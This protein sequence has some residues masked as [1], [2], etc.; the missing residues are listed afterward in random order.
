MLCGN[1]AAAT[2]SNANYCSACGAR[3]APADFVDGERRQVTALFCDLVGSTEIAARLDPEQWHDIAKHYRQ[4][5]GGEIVKMG[6]HVT[7]YLGDG[8]VA[9]FGYPVAE[10][11]ASERAVRAGLAIVQSMAALNE[12]YGALH[13]VT[14]AVRVGLHSG[15]VVVAR[16]GDSEIGMFGDTPNIAARV[17]EAARP[18]TVVM[19][20]LVH[21]AVAGLFVVEALGAHAFK[22]VEKP[23]QLFRALRRDA[24][25]RRAH[26]GGSRKRTNFVGRTDEMGALLERQRRARAGNGQVVLI[27]GEAGIGKTRLLEEFRAGLKGK[28]HLWLDCGGEPL[29]SNTP[30]HA[31]AQVLGLGA[32]GE[33]RKKA[34]VRLLQRALV[35]AKLNIAETLPL[36]AEMLDLPVPERVQPLA[37]AAEQKR[38]QLLEVLASWVLNTARSEELLAIAIEDVHWV[39]PSTIE[40]MQILAERAAGERLLIVATARPDFRPPWPMQ[41]HHAQIALSRLDRTQTRALVQG[42]VDQQTFDRRLIESLAERADGVPLFAEELARN[43]MDRGD[44]GQYEI[45]P[46]LRDSLTAR[47]DR[48][49]QAKAVA[50]L[51]AVI[52][53]EFEYGLLRAVSMLPEDVID[54]ALAS[55]AEADLLY[56]SG[57]PPAATYRFKHAL[58]RDAAY[59][60]L[61]KSQRR[62]L[63]GRV[64]RTISDKFT[65]L[66][67]AHPEIL[68]YHWSEAGDSDLA[69]DA[70]TSAARGLAARHAYKEAA[71][72]FG[73]ALTSLT[74]LPESEDRASR[75]LKIWRWLVGASQIAYGYSAAE[76][77]QATQM[78]QRLAEKTGDLGKQ[79]AHI[80]GEWMAASSAGDYQSAAKLADQLLPIAQQRGVRDGLATAYMI[81]TT[82]RCR[83]GDLAGAEEAFRAGEPLF[84]TALYARRPGAAAQAFG[85]GAVNAWVIGDIAEARRRIQPV[86]ELARTSDNPYE[87]AFSQY[88]AAWVAALLGDF[89]LAREFANGSIEQSA[90]GRFPH[91]TAAASIVLG[92][93]LNALGEPDEGARLMLQG[94]RAQGDTQARSG[95]TMYLTW[96]AAAHHA[97]NRLDEAVATLDR[98]LEI[99]PQEVFYRPETLRLRGDYLRH[100][101]DLSS[102]A[103]AYDAA[104]D[105][106]RKIGASSL[107]ARASANRDTLLMQE[108]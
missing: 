25:K 86:W 98:A 37:L 46:T 21:D 56:A 107:L 82:T 101:G 53:R 83:S 2:L 100:T 75:E 65:T 45:P 80:A 93:A 22:G 29:F 62:L 14:L 89:E 4:A 35:G 81:L 40:L 108:P 85:N 64:G 91:F 49:G 44:T 51:G 30:F 59:D 9:Y 105:L 71:D 10:E 20:T 23:I 67:E 5:T 43:A 19:T 38:R 77:R 50:Q 24:R 76:T 6:G 63:H 96:L 18:N 34:R 72:A 78:A 92:H 39:D 13:G 47:L 7:Q 8:V 55:L 69:T 70:W 42:A 106:A 11:D 12:R 48:L 52:G 104:M 95:L 68:A 28:P 16:G 103:A 99:N 26:I 3:L 41:A 54:S 90:E 97:C 31:V 57:P 58:V 60:G 74:K 33:E 61:L 36:V 15:S 17:Q 27:T 79:F 66:A 84:S 88:M 32:W 73:R 102:A 87:L 1:C 94:L